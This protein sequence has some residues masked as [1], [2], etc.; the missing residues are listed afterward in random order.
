MHIVSH[1][2]SHDD[3]RDSDQQSDE[4][5]VLSIKALLAEARKM[6]AKRSWHGITEGIDHITEIMEQE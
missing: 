5:A 2:V 3:W 4:D 6:A 1:H